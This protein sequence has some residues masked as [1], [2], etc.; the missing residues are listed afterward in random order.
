MSTLMIMLKN[1]IIF[2][3][4]AVPGYLLV[5]G[6]L[7]GQKESGTLSKL[8]TNVGMPFLIL[9]STLKL[10]FSGEFT[11]TIIIAG[12]V[13]IIFTVLMF[14]AS[15]FVVRW[16]SDEKRR[17]MMRFCMTFAN[18]GFI[19]I[20]LA[21]AVF[22]EASPVMAYL[23]ILNIITNVLMFTLGVY[24]ISGDKNAINVKKA[25]LNPVLIAFLV[26]VVLNLAGVPTLVPEL[27]T[28]ATYFS[29]IV[30]PISMVVLGM[31][32][33]GVQMSRLFNSWR[34]YY[35]SAFR[36]A[37]FPAVIVAIL[38]LLRGIPALSVNTDM[39][40]GFFVAIAMPTAGLA[41]AFSDQYNGDTDNAVIFTLGTTI[42]SVATIPVLY[43]VL[44]LFV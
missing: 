13:G 2:V 30:T 7:L 19:G 42:L 20:P 5:K 24:L 23:I 34:M 11:K 40:I 17:G 29:N 1:V 25:V 16:E 12:V 4:L 8:L 6:K 27:Q 14:L 15:A 31:K 22:G 43:W 39:I 21:R 33:A 26:G 44:R 28:Y 38:M 10:E 32:L 36:L 9:S 41:S 37:V 18:N 3:L 35:V